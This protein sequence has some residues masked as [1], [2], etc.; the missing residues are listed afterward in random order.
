[1]GKICFFVH[2]FFAF[3]LVVILSTVS[4]QR[5]AD[6]SKMPDASQRR[7]LYLNRY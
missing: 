5:F 2:R 4:G 3:S 1:M 7:A 6:S